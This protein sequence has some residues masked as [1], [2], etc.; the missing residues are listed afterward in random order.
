MQYILFFAVWSVAFLYFYSNLRKEKA[1]LSRSP[2][3]HPFF[4]EIYRLSFLPPLKWL[5][6]DDDALSPKGMEIKEKLILTG[7]SRYFTV[8][9]FT[10][11]KWLV[12][13]LC[14]ALGILTVTT[15]DQLAVNAKVL[16]LSMF[17]VG[18]LLPNM[19]LNTKY[20][21]A[22]IDRNKDLPLIMMFTILLLRSNK[23]VS[24]ILFALS[25][26]NTYYKEVFERGY[27][28]FLRNQQEGISFLRSNFTNARIKEMFNL[29][30]DIAEYAR[31]ECI[32]ILEGNMKSLIEETNR[33][34]R[35]NDMSRLVYSQATMMVPFIA[36]LLLGAA[37]IVGLGIKIFSNSF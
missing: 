8:R 21:K 27:R 3:A 14:L 17:M 19:F 15:V 12:L 4:R 13:T 33:I 10:A 28:I 30:E 37:P 1:S 6:E 26:I 31:D 35:R 16:V 36:I 18:A 5:V 32:Q 25:K 20:K 29:L 7:Y 9:S 23:T 22:I 11:F 34:K 2:I 24:E